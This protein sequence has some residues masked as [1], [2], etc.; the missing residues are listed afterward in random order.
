MIEI[1]LDKMRPNPNQPRRRFEGLEELAQSLRDEGQLTPVLV[2][3]NGDGY[4]LVSGERRWRAAKLAGLEVLRA[5][6]R[7]LTDELAYRLSLIENVAR[8]NLTPIEE[9]QAFRK[10]IDDGKTQAEVGGL[11]GKSQQYVADRL[12]LLRLP[13]KVQELVTARAV[14]PSV[15]RR[16]VALD[17]EKLQIELAE[18]AAEGD[19]TVRDVERM[20]QVREGE[21]LRLPPE[22]YEM[23]GVDPEHWELWTTGLIE[24]GDV[25]KGEYENLGKMLA[26]IE[27]G[28]PWWTADWFAYGKERNWEKNT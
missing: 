19:L 13:D 14:N 2:R 6:V 28:L 18:R 1:S 23:F 3:P 8:A 9:A 22:L 15:A 7:E 17:D 5:E 16:L 27:S 12:A 21:L 10:L 11:V 4:E 25:S 24:R 26:F 20:K